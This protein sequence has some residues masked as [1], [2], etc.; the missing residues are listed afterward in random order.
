ME[1]QNNSWSEIPDTTCE[2][3]VHVNKILPLKV[4]FLVETQ[5]NSLI[6]KEDQ[7]C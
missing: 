6:E 4:S 5:H 7:T 2:S 3:L 1:E